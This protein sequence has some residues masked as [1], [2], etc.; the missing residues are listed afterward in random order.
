[1]YWATDRLPMSV[2]R[3]GLRSGTY[4]ACPLKLFLYGI[5]SC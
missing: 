5:T 1:M 2:F 4:V 3:E